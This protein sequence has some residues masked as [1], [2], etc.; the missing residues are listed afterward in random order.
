MSKE[1]GFVVIGR[2][3]GNRLVDCLTSIAAYAPQIV[4]V[5]SASTDQSVAYAQSQHVHVLELDMSVKFTAARARNA[6]FAL[7]LQHYPDI[8]YVHFVDGDCMVNQAWVGYALDFLNHHVQVAV[9]CGRRRERYPQA[10]P[11]NQL[12]DIE[13]DTPTGKAKACGGDAIMRAAVFKQVGGFNESLIA[14]EEPELCIRIRQQ[15]FDVWRLDQEMTLHD[16]AITRFAQWWKR[17]VRAGYAYAEG[18]HLHGAAPEHHWVNESRRAWLWGGI[19]PVLLLIS[20]LLC[21]LLALAIASLFV[22]QYVRLWRKHQH[23]GRFS[24]VYV[25]YLML[26]KVAE[27]VGQLR[28]FWHRLLNVKSTLIEYK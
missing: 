5:D 1:I 16:A 14:G 27:M 21:P 19:L 12:C 20:L 26:G 17:T 7:L 15:G 22:V 18:S 28:Y 6:G 11:Y 23:L 2:N 9:A 13:W 24:A 4:Y 8:R 10:T 25:K 3:E